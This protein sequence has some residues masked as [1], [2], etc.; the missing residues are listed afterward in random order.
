MLLPPVIMVHG[1]FCGG[2]SLEAIARP[3]EAQGYKVLRP[4][5][6][7]HAPGDAPSAAAG[8]SMI[9]YVRAIVGL[10]RTQPEP[11]ILIGHS[12]GGLV[13]MLAASRT[14]VRA[15]ALL[16][17]SAPW[18]TPV[19]SLE[20][21]VAAF[22]VQMLGP[23]WT[24]AVPP[25]PG[26]MLMHGLSLAEP[27]VQAATIGRLRFESARAL[28]QTLNWWLDP[29]MSTKLKAAPLRTPALTLVG[30]RDRIHAPA[31]VKLTA[32]RIG[33]TFETLPG[34]SHWLVVEPRAPEIAARI[35]TWLETV[36]EPSEE[37]A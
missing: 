13:A 35:L 4:D 20:E 18:G 2:W 3:F 32:Q 24:G 21:A 7:G 1:A 14:P 22:G 9:D 30:D 6:P 36:P 34:M 12:L 10:C 8:L 28:G 5:L 15:L 11:P 17:P 19:G 37:L 26:L 25:E 31:S 29:F 16:A 33:A 23:L 27:E